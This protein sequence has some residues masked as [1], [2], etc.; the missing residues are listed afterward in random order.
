MRPLIWTLSGL[1][2]IL[3]GG[4]DLADAERYWPQWRGPYA[5]GAASSGNPPVEWSETRNVRWKVEIPG[6]GSASPIV[7]GDRI[8]VLTAV[9]VSSEP[10]PRSGAEE[11]RGRGIPRT[12]PTEVQQFTV[13][14]F[15]RQDG[16]LLWKRVCREEL[17]HQGTHATGSWASGSPLTDGERVYAYFGSWGLYCL[18]LEGNLLWEKDF[19]QMDIRL[20]FGEG[21]SPFLSGDR[22]IINWDHEGQ[23]FIAALDKL[24]GREI[25]RVE[26]DEMTSWATPVVV[27]HAGRKQIITNATHRVRSYD[28]E[29]GELLWECRGMTL[30][31]IPSPVAADGLV[32]VTS[33]FRGNAL[34]AIRLDGA[35]GD[36]TGSEFISWSLDRD[37][38]YAPS[39][40]LYDGVL[41]FLKSN[42]GIL[43]AVEARSGRAYYQERLPEL[44]TVYASPVGASGRIYVAGRDGETVVVR[45]GPEF[46][47][48]A[49]NTLED[50][51]DASPAVVGNELFLR[52]QRHLYCLAEEA[53]SH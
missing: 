36:I 9:P 39:P 5:T 53:P 16:Q 22:C 8:F 49:V 20:G 42:S 12:R 28:F 3:A 50:G 18:D 2:W 23:S 45:H 31:T 44:S 41:Y 27:E 6:R 25:W 1:V 7:W 52:G 26:R 15:R 35:R 21:A 29:T 17:P 48:L 34:L 32:F 47:V 51:F 11:A 40:L 43:S 24:T 19:G 10:A 46:Q 33:G 30:N 13:L 37:T 14:A 38:P 4:T